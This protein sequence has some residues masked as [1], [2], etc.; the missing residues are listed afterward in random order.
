MTIEDFAVQQARK[1]LPLATNGS[2]VRHGEWVS[3]V[4]KG[5]KITFRVEFKR[6]QHHNKYY[7]LIYKWELNSINRKTIKR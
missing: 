5:E 1:Q 6:L 2:R 7:E 3:F 4:H